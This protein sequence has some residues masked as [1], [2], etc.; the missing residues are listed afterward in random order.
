[1]QLS[2]TVH[3][4][5]MCLHVRIMHTISRQYTTHLHVQNSYMYIDVYCDNGVNARLVVGSRL[6]L[7]PEI[8]SKTSTLADNSN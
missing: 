6:A 8:V 2:G 1:M 7:L 5:L 4:P 3:N